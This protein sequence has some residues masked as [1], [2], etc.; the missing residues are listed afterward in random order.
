MICGLEMIRTY[1]T[2]KNLKEEF[3]I[4]K[5]LSRQVNRKTQCLNAS[6]DNKKYL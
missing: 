5:F 1:N 4:A 6:N 2:S 3:R